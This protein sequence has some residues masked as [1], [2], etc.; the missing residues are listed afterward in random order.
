MIHGLSTLAKV[1]YKGIGGG[2]TR[3]K[4]NT[5]LSLSW[6]LAN[7]WRLI[8][9]PP[10]SLSNLSCSERDGKQLI[11]AVRDDIIRESV[12]GAARGYY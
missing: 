1:L 10:R 7:L 9:F 2:Q 6:N 4:C 11:G 5:A 3:R 12:S 8:F